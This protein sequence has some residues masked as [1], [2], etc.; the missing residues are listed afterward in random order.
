VIEFFLRRPIFAAVCSLIIL[1]AGLV[2]I[3]TLPIAQFPKVAPPVVTV[4][5]TYVGASAEAVEDSVTT[6][7]EEGINGVQG[8]RYIS[9]QS[10]NNGTSTI[11]CTFDLERNL[12]L[13]A[14]DVQ[15][16]IQT[17]QARLPAEVVAQGITVNKNAGDFVLGFGIST[18]NKS[19]TPLFMSNYAD[20]YIK[21][22]LK[23]IPGVSDVLIFGERKYAMRL[24]LDPKKLADNG[25]A[26]T[27]VENALSDQNVQVAAGALGAPP[28]TGNQP[29]QISVRA[30]GRLSTPD[31]FMSLILKNNPDGGH[32]YL[33]D[34]G[35]AEIGAEDY[36]SDLR[37]NGQSA[38][39]LGV[40]ALPTANALDV[41]KA[42][43]ARMIELSAKFPPGMYDEVAFDTTTFVNES[44]KEVVITL[45][46]AIALVIFVI[47]I[48]L[49]DWRT[50]LIPAITIPVSLIGTFALMKGLGFSINTL[51][52]F[53]LTLATG[54]VVDDAIVVIENIARFIQE[55]RMSPLAGASAAMQ[56]ITGAVV[57][58]SLVL[59]AVFIP[60]AFFPGETGQLYKQFALTIACSITI[61]L[62][63]ALTLTPTLSALLLG[64]SERPRN[65]FF[66]AFN[67]GI[68]RLRRWYH[69]SLGGLLRFRYVIVVLF[70][71]ALVMTGV[72]F[73]ST[74]TGFT[75]DED[76]GYFIVSLQAP[77][78]VSMDYTERVAKHVEDL[79]RSH[80]E[81]VR[82]FDVIGF[83]FSGNG[84]NKATMFVLLKDWADRPG[85]MHSIF[86]LLYFPGGMQSQFSQVPEAQ[87]F[88]FNPPAISG[89]G[90]VGGFQY[91][92]EDRG[93]VG[94]QELNRVAYEFIGAGNRNPKLSNVYTSFRNDNPQLVV[95]V[96]RNK[97]Q[98]LD[99]PL[100]NIFN[101]M[102]IYLGSLYVNDFDYLN[103]SYR[104]YIQADA[105][106]RSTLHDLQT[107]YV[108][109][110]SGAI[111]P[112]STLITG[113]QSKSA[114]VITHYNLFRSIEISGQPAQGLGSG[115]AIAAMT[116]LAKQF[117]SANVTHEWSGISLDEIQ[118][119]SQSVLIFALGIIVVFLVLAA[120]YESW[121][122]PLII[123]MAVPIAILGA[124][125]AVIARDLIAAA[126]PPIGFVVSDVYAQVGYVMLIGLASKNA[127]L[128]V[129]FAN[130]LREQGLDAASAAKQAAETRLRP[131]LMTSF[132]FILGILPLV[133]ASGAG[134]ASRHSLGTPVFGGMI[135]STFVNLAL[136][137]VIYV[138][139]VNLR[140]RG[141]RRGGSG[142]S[143]G[144]SKT[145]T[146]ALEPTPIQART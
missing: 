16:A 104:V 41:V 99:V 61:S 1:L 19:L 80:S 81:V 30:L 114:P 58:T 29:Y 126:I 52:L 47:Y 73:K 48:F 27:D 84:P 142:G 69:A 4:T 60:V 89:V 14:T 28:T 109:S 95:D 119:G 137:P 51:T 145:R 35:R 144:G 118:S 20:L 71:A 86:P 79:I 25:L 117:E 21:N 68:D 136:V 134:S 22:E 92:L 110:S 90:N 105:P 74:P 127:I 7:L 39:G 125:V 45:L 143:S 12:D 87:I 120:Q 122:D 82:V 53:G 33:R 83:G 100:A 67:N 32:V 112:L 59:L 10:S 140:E 78:G 49:Q 24:W 34:V 123:L 128:I 76:Q 50:T 130:Q 107:I 102:Q 115:D 63:N 15:N 139:V 6:I 108:K 97:A 2:A 88:A 42:A 133:F 64:R 62:F 13:A 113:T 36:T 132:A 116:G 141:K 111:M 8:L 103:R 23:R 11:T 96:D 77:E 101:T 54:L 38:V 66:V 70:I 5:S 85:F 9:S 146:T 91:E 131:I 93:N 75:P 18:H 40:Q 31:Q 57:A 72:L 121:T 56:E 55:K 106:Y 43:R 37:L 94:L 3:P 17:V 65:R 98:S 44:I 124:L 46:I 26:A 138:L 129:E 135:L